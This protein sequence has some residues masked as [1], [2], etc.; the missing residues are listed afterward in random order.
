M[1]SPKKEGPDM[2]LNSNCEL[3]T[4]RFTNKAI[5]KPKAQKGKK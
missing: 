4:Y 3:K 2:L 1:A 5:S